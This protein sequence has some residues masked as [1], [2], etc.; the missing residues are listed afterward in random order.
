V[1][2]VAGGE[3]TRSAYHSQWPVFAPSLDTD[4]FFDQITMELATE[5]VL[6][7]AYK[8]SRSKHSSGLER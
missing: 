7:K 2:V 6:Q 3:E 5:L 8:E 4:V 1:I